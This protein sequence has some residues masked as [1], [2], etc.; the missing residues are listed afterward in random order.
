MCMSGVHPCPDCSRL[1]GQGTALVHAPAP[2]LLCASSAGT[3]DTAAGPAREASSA[4]GLTSCSSPA[5]SSLTSTAWEGGGEGRGGAC[6]RWLAH[7]QG[8]H[9]GGWREAFA[10]PAA[11]CRCTTLALL[12]V[13]LPVSSLLAARGCQA[14]SQQACRGNGA[15]ASVPHQP[16]HKRPPT[17][18][19]ASA[20][21][22]LKV[23]ARLPAQQLARA[24]LDNHILVLHASPST[25]QTG[26]Q[27]QR[28][29]KEEGA[30]N[31]QRSVWQRPHVRCSLAPGSA[32][33]RCQQRWPQQCSCSACPSTWPRVPAPATS[34]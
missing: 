30:A 27:T 2:L 21:V 29:R 20:Q 33:R 5:Q 23:A 11:A 25:P 7:D 24:L 34:P 18:L 14:A 3:E 15:S 4:S 6:R 9:G 22:E 26:R 13:C 10:L 28:R 17:H 19:H 32:P 1:A 31:W 8:I 16:P 12:V